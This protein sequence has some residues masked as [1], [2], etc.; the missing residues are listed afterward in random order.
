MLNWREE[1][2]KEDML[3]EGFDVIEGIPELSL[4]C[5]NFNTGIRFYLEVGRIHED[6]NQHKKKVIKDFIKLGENVKLAC[7]GPKRIFYYNLD[8]NLNKT[9][10]GQADITSRIGLEQKICPFCGYEWTSRVAEPKECPKCKKRIDE[11]DKVKCN[12]C[13]YEWNDKSISESV[14][15]PC[16]MNEIKITE[17]E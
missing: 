17:R 1:A 9:I 4:K 5:I 7:V 3:K 10:A 11:G 12:Y 15:C 13:G 2:V 16:C 6:L 8:K 14:I